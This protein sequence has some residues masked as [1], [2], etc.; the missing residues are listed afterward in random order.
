MGMART[1][2]VVLGVV[3]VA[4]GVA[5]LV[6]DTPLLGLFE[7][8]LLHNLVHL[9]LGAILLFGATTTPAAVVTARVIGGLLAVLGLLGFFEPFPDLVPL[10]GNDIWLHLSSGVVLLTAGFLVPGVERSTA[11]AR[12]LGDR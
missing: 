12:S 6:L 4:A 8:N 11:E 7:V 3:Y 2:V 1:V 9:A 5:G 10:G